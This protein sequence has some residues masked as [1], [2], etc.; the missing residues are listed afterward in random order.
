[1]RLQS[2]L[3]RSLFITIMAVTLAAG[4]T[5]PALAAAAAQPVIPNDTQEWGND[6]IRVAA[7]QPA[8]LSV[9]PSGGSM[10]SSSGSG[11]SGSSLRG[12]AGS[13]PADGTQLS[14]DYCVELALT[15]GSSGPYRLRFHVDGAGGTSTS[16]APGRPA[17]ASYRPVAGRHLPFSGNVTLT[18]DLA[19]AADAWVTTT[20]NAGLSGA[21]YDATAQLVAGDGSGGRIA[22]SLPTGDYSLVLQGT[23]QLTGTFTA[24][25]DQG[26]CGN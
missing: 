22:A 11:A 26:T 17:A 16:L 24:T 12:G 4:L 3:T 15:D 10:Q 20:G 21:I 25:A 19:T 6:K 14:V 8:T 18:F 9:S 7:T 5:A 1:M 23:S 2:V 13:V